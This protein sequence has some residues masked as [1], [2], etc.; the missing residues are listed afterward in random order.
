MWGE[1]VFENLEQV[2]HIPI[3]AQLSGYEQRYVSK[4]GQDKISEMRAYAGRVFFFLF[5]FNENKNCCS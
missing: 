5:C 3:T 4:I 1:V 2:E